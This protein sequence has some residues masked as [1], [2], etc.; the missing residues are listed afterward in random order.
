M[1]KVKLVST[2]ENW[3]VHGVHGVCY[4]S[5]VTERDMADA[6]LFPLENIDTWI[7]LIK[8][9]TGIETQVYDF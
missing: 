9:M 8:D 6:E 5:W 4:I 3:F 2:D 1:T 7:K